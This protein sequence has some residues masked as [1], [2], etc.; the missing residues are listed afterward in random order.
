MY[1]E[2][3]TFMPSIIYHS[4]RFLCPSTLERPQA[5]SLHPDGNKSSRQRE[6]KCRVYHALH[7]T[8]RH[9][10]AQRQACA[11]RD[12]LFFDLTHNSGPVHS[13]SGRGKLAMS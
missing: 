3:L 6:A 2:M 8:S 1:E 10:F 12:F 7:S 4:L 5:W 11:V 9:S 13:C